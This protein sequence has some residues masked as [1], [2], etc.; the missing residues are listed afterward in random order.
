MLVPV[1]RDLQWCFD[2]PAQLTAN[3]QGMIRVY[4]SCFGSRIRME[5]TNTSY[6]SDLTG[7]GPPKCSVLEGKSPKL[8]RE[9]YVGEIWKFGRMYM[10]NYRF[11]TWWLEM[12]GRQSWIFLSTKRDW[13]PFFFFANRLN[14][15]LLISP[16]YGRMSPLENECKSLVLQKYP[17]KK[18]LI[19]T[20]LTHN[21]K[22]RLQKGAVSSWEW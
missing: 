12:V 10:E 9:V 19:G 7:P 15:T 8:C 4:R 18:L 22:P 11:A 14:I 6:H 21:P 5:P 17:V 20:R 2:P 1:K 13:L 16:F 3:L